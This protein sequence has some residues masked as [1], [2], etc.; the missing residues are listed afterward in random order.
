LDFLQELFEV[1]MSLTDTFKELHMRYIIEAQRREMGNASPTP[2]HVVLWE[3]RF[4]ALPSV[5]PFLHRLCYTVSR[6][7]T[8]YLDAK[9]INIKANEL[10]HQFE[11]VESNFRKL[12]DELMTCLHRV[13]FAN[14]EPP[15]SP[16]ALPRD[17]INS[18]RNADG[19]Q[20]LCGGITDILKNVL[21]AESGVCNLN[22]FRR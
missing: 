19:T 5:E 18:F 16:P 20:D 6:I 12:C 14:H 22:D 2:V 10:R 1:V 8:I 15:Q 3:N 4:G 21:Q 9:E 7:M 13:N 11:S 17:V